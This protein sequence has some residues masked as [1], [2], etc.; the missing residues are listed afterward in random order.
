MLPRLR[1][2]T[3]FRLTRLVG[4]AV[5]CAIAVAYVQPIRA[6]MEAK[7]EVVKRRAEQAALMSKQSKLRHRLELTEAEAFIEREARRIGLVRPGEQLYIVKGME[8][9]NRAHRGR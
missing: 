3:G 8:K 7:D 4:V 2:P 5:V 9:W 1:F 6:Y